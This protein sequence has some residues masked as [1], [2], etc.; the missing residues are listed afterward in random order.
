MCMGT[1]FTVR[2]QCMGTSTVD[3]M[4]TI[5][6]LGTHAHTITRVRLLVADL[7]CLSYN[8]V[9]RHVQKISHFTKR[10][11][12]VFQ[13]TSFGCL[14]PC[15][16][17]SRNPEKRYACTRVGWDAWDNSS[18]NKES[19]ACLHYSF[20]HSFSTCLLYLLAVPGWRV[21]P[22]GPTPSLARG[23]AERRSG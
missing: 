15:V 17:S 5:W 13:T 1:L 16:K 7:C 21:A 11:S 10:I 12:C 3:L 23:H 4:F 8:L 14:F 6:R 9:T 19:K 22:P 2:R 18:P 20:I